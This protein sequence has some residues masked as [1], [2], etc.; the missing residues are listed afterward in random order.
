MWSVSVVRQ[1]PGQFCD[2]QT[3]PGLRRLRGGWI[4]GLSWV[5]T[6]VGLIVPRGMVG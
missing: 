4:G 6:P 5:P 3:D 2:G 1:E